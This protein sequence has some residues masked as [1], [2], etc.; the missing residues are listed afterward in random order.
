MCLFKL[1]YATH[2][3]PS[4]Q[5]RKREKEKRQY[6]RQGILFLQKNHIII[7]IVP[8]P[9]KL[10]KNHPLRILLSTSLKTLLHQCNQALLIRT[11]HLP[12]LLPILKHEE[13]GHGAH[14]ELLRHVGELVDVELVETRVG[15]DF[16][17]FD[18]FGGDYFAGAAPGCHLL[19]VFFC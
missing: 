12:D 14:A 18:D 11:H 8:L 3:S 10:T 2:L 19:L 1:P 16:G 15:L 17:H 13:S 7:T 4:V 9:P 6:S 5:K